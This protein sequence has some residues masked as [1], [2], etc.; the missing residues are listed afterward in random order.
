MH[1]SGGKQN[2]YVYKCVGTE[3]HICFIGQGNTTAHGVQHRPVHS[4]NYKR[5]QDL[6]MM[7]KEGKKITDNL[8]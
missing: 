4:Y 3:V 2:V 7:E 5:K 6:M 1:T 8:I